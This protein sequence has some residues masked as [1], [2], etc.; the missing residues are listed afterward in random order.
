MKRLIVF[1]ITI[2][3]GNPLWGQSLDQDLHQLQKKFHAA[4]VKALE[5]IRSIYS[6]QLAAIEEKARKSGDKETLADVLVEMD[7][8]KKAIA[9]DQAEGEK[10]QGAKPMRQIE[11]LTERVLAVRRVGKVRLLFGQ[12]VTRSTAFEIAVKQSTPVWTPSSMSDLEGIVECFQDLMKTENFRQ[13]V[14]LNLR[15][16]ASGDVFNGEGKKITSGEAHRQWVKAHMVGNKEGE[17]L[18]LSVGVFNSARVDL[19]PRRSDGDRGGAIL[20]SQP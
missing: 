11:G 10:L 3:S 12:E 2:L 20:L 7:T 5:P 1:I 14:I 17:Y 16:E 8:L 4:S 18:F 19:L 15:I 6:K 13:V 9:F